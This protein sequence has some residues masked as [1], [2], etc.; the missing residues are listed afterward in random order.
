MTDRTTLDHVGLV[1]RDLDA[2]LQAAAGLGFAPT[3]PRELYGRDPATGRAVSLEQTSAHL[4][5]AQG[6]VELS[7]VHSHSDRHHLARYL[8]RYAGLHILALGVVDIAA[9]QRRCAA[10]GLVT[11]A[12][13]SASRAIEYGDRHGQAQFEWFMLADTD[14]PEGLTCFVRHLTPELVFQEA[15]QAHPNGVVSLQ[16]I[17][18]VTRDPA[19]ESERWSALTGA[20]AVAGSSGFAFDLGDGRL[21]LLTPGSYAER[22]PGATS[23]PCPGFAGITVRCHDPQAALAVAGRQGM[24]T[25]LLPSGGFYAL[26]AG[27][28]VEF[29]G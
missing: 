4:V 10:A 28:L 15:V 24:A 19:A 1:G 16:A 14:S 8:D 12:V 27:C 22:F 21:E 29:I 2:L 13:A 6:Y 20:R 9:A 7:A 11:T 18:V 26:A 5:F 23:P 3:A 17:H 25:Q